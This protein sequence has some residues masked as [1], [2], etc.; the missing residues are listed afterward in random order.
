MPATTIRRRRPQLLAALG[1]VLVTLCVACGF[2]A[3]GAIQFDSFLG[4]D[5]VVPEAAWFPLI[6]EVKNDGPTFTGTIEVV[7][8][9]FNSGQRQEVTLELPSGTMKRI[10]VPLFC[11]TRGLCSYDARLLDEHRR[12]RAEQPG[13]QPRNQTLGGVPLLGALTRNRSGTPVIKALPSQRKDF[14]PVSAAFLA[15]M[16]PD[17][18]L[19]LEGMTVFYLNSERASELKEEQ[20]QALFG[21]INAGGHLIVGIEQAGDVSATTW[22][23]SLMPGDLKGTVS[24]ASHPELQKWLQSR[25]APLDRQAEDEDASPGGLGRAPSETIADDYKFEM[26]AMP[27]IDT[28]LREGKILLSAGETP[29]IVQSHRG[30]G[31]VTVLMFSP[32]REPLRS[33][34]NLPAFWSKLADVPPQWYDQANNKARGG[35]SS[36]GIFAA[37]LETSQVHKLPI[38]WLLLLLVVYLIVIGPL[39]RL[40]L[41]RIDRPM[42]T[43]VTFPAYVVFFSFLIYYIG[44]RLRAGES[45][46]NELHIVDV[47]ENGSRAELHGH[48]Y[49]SLYSP[50]NQRY[51][52]SSA[53]RYAALRG[54][55]AG[56]W[57]GNAQQDDKM[58]VEQRGDG[59]RSDIFVPVW[60]S[61]FLASDWWDTDTAPVN[62]SLSGRL[63]QNPT[64]KMENRTGINLTNLK[65][66][67]GS[68]I[69]NLGNLSSNQTRSVELLADEGTSFSSMEGEYA[70]AFQ[71]AVRAHQSSFGSDK[72][73]RIADAAGASVAAC[74]LSH[75]RAK[76]HD[77]TFLC[78]AG[79]D[80][81]SAI[82]NDRAVF[83]AWA[84]DYA[85]GKSMCQFKPKRFHKNTLFRI[86]VEISP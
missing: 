36:D 1:L 83:F 28:K 27:V 76:E 72:T 31:K 3:S 23:K 70:H 10:V 49:A 43:W 80:V 53:Q 21:W 42:L 61:Q 32:E 59:F 62:I 75:F 2:R 22:L 58:L 30:M 54:E 86:P 41:K 63:E 48:T 39:D 11:T 68:K 64:V 35:W 52:I 46:W 66:A 5:G 24:L 16:I 67:V 19:A 47:L 77:M 44:Y 82:G 17:N 85:P 40:W 26:A 79:L 78:P 7:P 60:T 6:F 74:F 37:M 12:V 14:Q 25:D 4:Y 33:W 38:G 18:P 69:F 71:G 51:V 84:A 81:T 57:S 34:A 29:L 45:E 65:I 15:P 56:P 8:G 9:N 55:F 20:V 50:G 73:S 13:I